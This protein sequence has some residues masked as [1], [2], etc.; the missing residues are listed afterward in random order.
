MRAAAHMYH[1]AT[2]SDVEACLHTRTR[3]HTKHTHTHTHTAATDSDVEIALTE[4]V[5]LHRHAC[6]RLR[7][8]SICTFVPVKQVN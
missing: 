3:T 1:E 5:L 6:T 7:S 4:G 8:V 2:D